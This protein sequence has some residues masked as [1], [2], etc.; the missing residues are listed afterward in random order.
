[1]QKRTLVAKLKDQLTQEIRAG[2]LQ[3]ASAAKITIAGSGKHVVAVGG[4]MAC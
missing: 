1:M 2:E 4:D 3:T